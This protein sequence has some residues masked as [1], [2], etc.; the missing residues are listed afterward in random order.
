[1]AVGLVG[2]VRLVRLVKLVKLDESTAR[3]HG[4]LNLDN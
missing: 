4:K 1:M 2:L 3:R